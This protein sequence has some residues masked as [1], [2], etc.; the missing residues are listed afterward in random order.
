MEHQE[1]PGTANT[2]SSQREGMEPESSEVLAQSVAFSEL[3]QTL[4]N[5]GKA[6][7]KNLLD[8]KVQVKAELGRTLMEISEVLQLGPGSVIPLDRAIRQPVD[9][10]VENVCLA[11][12]EVVV[13]DDRF[14]IR[15]QSLAET[16]GKE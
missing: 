15:I 13:V 12:G 2:P 7:L 3:E 5:S 10:L 1:N 6:S 4:V 11:R 14:A 8:V 9:L 16:G